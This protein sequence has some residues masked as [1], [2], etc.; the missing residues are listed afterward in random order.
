MPFDEDYYGRYMA[1]RGVAGEVY[2][3]PENIVRRRGDGGVG[4]WLRER[5]IERIKQLNLK[6]ENEAIALAMSVAE[7]SGITPTLRQAYTR[8]GAAHL[9]AVSGLH[10][11]FICVMANLLLAWVAILRHGQIARSMV[12]VAVI[13]MFAAMAGFTPSIVRA[14]VMFSI[15]Q[16]SLQLASRTDALNTL[17]LTAFMMLAWDA[18]MLHD[19]G[20]L[21][22]FVAV[23]AI[24][25]WGVPLFPQRSRGLTARAWR[26]LASGIATS[27]VATIATLPLT[28]YLFGE[29]SLWSVVTGTIMVALA[30]VTVGAAMLWI[31]FPIGA[32]QGVATHIIGGVTEAMNTIAAWSDKV[33][34]LA[35]EVRIDGWLCVAIYAI[36]V[37]AT[38][39]VWGARR[40]I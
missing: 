35:T 10:V 18:R 29:V 1:A 5:A 30:A 13:W 34:V 23:A 7:R 14:A 24:I 4:K 33:G 32:F 28:A 21:L 8:G 16:L 25:E 17:S 27:A 39:I 36:M 31:L 12:V 3:A 38:I 26:W 40:R 19:A 20:F 11:G 2:I 15:L 9:L 22:S 6:P 37:V